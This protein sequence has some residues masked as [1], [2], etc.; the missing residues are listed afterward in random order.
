MDKS[1]DENNFIHPSFSYFH[2]KILLR[3]F[4]ED[5]SGWQGQDGTSKQ[6]FIE[7]SSLNFDLEIFSLHP[8]H[9]IFNLI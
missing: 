7:L 9:F 8:F 1:K 4:S 3:I 2:E 5:L 6:Y